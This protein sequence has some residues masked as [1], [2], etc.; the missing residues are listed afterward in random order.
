M[1]SIS[2]TDAIKNA[3][4]GGT[5][6]AGLGGGGGPQ[7]LVETPADV[8]L[9]NAPNLEAITALVSRLNRQAQES[10][11]PGGKELAEQSSQNI[12]NLLSGQLPASFTNQLQTSLAQ[13]YGARGGFGVDTGAMNAAALRSMG[14]QSMALQSEGEKEYQ[15]ALG[16]APKVDVTQFMLTP[17]RYQNY[18]S[19]QARQAAEAAR[20]SEQRREYDLGLEQRNQQYQA[21]L[22]S[23]RMQAAQA[24]NELEEKKREYNITRDTNVLMEINQLQERARQAT[25]S[26]QQAQQDLNLQTWKTALQYMDPMFAAGQAINTR[27]LP[28]YVTTSLP[29][30]QR[31]NIPMIG[32]LP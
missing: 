18:L 26:A 23:A 8:N 10:A 1:P 22:E 25:M 9:A 4:G 28:Q 7:S 31:P 27:Q 3:F 19:E 5:P 12:A 32:A 14:L 20:L 2:D 24:N 15:A 29:T 13:Q 17:D 11:L 6:G 16:A 30:Y 21:Q